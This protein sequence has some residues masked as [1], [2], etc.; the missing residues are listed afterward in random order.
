MSGKQPQR[1][2]NSASSNRSVR[3]KP[4]GLS[5]A[6]KKRARRKAALQEQQVAQA[7]SLAKAN[8]KSGLAKVPANMAG[9][10]LTKMF[11]MPNETQT[12]R[13]PTAEMPPVA[14]A[15]LRKIDDFTEVSTTGFMSGY[16]Y[17]YS[18][19]VINYGQP[20]LTYISGPHYQE[21]ALTTL[22]YFD[23]GGNVDGLTEAAGS[24]GRDWLLPISRDLSGDGE[25][26]INTFW[27]LAK[28]VHAIV[29][30]GD[31]QQRPLLVQDGVSYAWLN[32]RE[33]V[34]LD[35]GRV[36]VTQEQV[37]QGTFTLSV[38]RLTDFG[39]H[40]ELVG[41]RTF[42]IDGVTIQGNGPPNWGEAL[43][44][45]TG[46]W[47][48]I[49]IDRLTCTLGQIKEITL[50]L[51]FVTLEKTNIFHLHY[52]PE[53]SQA[54]SIGQIARRTASTI[55]ITNTS[56]ALVAQGDVIATRLQATFPGMDGWG[57]FQE[58]VSSAKQ[59]Y[60]GKASKGC[61]TYMEL[62]TKEEA[63]CDY[64]NQWGA[65]LVRPEAMNMVNVITIVNA[66][67][68]TQPNTYLMVS[69]MIVEFRSESQL[70]ATAVSAL[71]YLE[72]I[73][74]RRISNMTDWFYENPMHWK[75]I[76][77]Y[78]KQA[79]SWTRSHSAAIGNIASVAFPEAA[80]AILP[81]SRFLQT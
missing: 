66:M 39:E 76:V 78:I 69:D 57:D 27:P 49:R 15:K 58:R 70:Y 71:P 9:M 59:K 18:L 2:S 25:D 44:N 46:G 67:R 13:I 56:S 33:H 31:L 32:P 80:P 38:H 79:W 47:Y 45:A 17:N 10:A 26:E 81:V 4:A 65:P 64:V 75:D 62:S 68:A 14:T 7:M 6:A 3:V 60:T 63:F 42:P 29:G 73:E 21:T 55:L 54:A 72:L 74:A 5:K 36:D 61:Y 28:V 35:G 37:A 50:K 11:M 16:D 20:S 23:V 48:A 34:F 40:P 22:P 77:N 43:F 30:K 24:M 41:H 12:M 51:K 53:L 19:L 1:R 52:M 8:V